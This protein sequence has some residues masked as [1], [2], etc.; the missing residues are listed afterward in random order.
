MWYSSTVMENFLTI[1]SRQLKIRE[2][3]QVIRPPDAPLDSTKTHLSRKDP[4]KLRRNEPD[5][6]PTLDSWRHNTKLLSLE[7]VALT[8]LCLVGS[9]RPLTFQLHM[10]N[11]RKSKDTQPQK[12]SKKSVYSPKTHRNLR[13][14][15][16]KLGEFFRLNNSQIHT[17]GPALSND[18][19]SQMID[20]TGSLTLA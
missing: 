8:T 9:L 4:P 17:E 14:V 5:T 2:L 1:T 3:Q 19:P 18:L 12:L 7:T 15:L 13:L 20:L 10:R 11:I 16:N 6:W